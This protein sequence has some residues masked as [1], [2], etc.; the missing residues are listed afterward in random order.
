VTCGSWH[1]YK[2][3]D[4]GHFIP[5]YHKQAFFTRENVHV[6][7]TRCN[8][9]YN[10]MHVIYRQWMV[11]KYGEDFIKKLES[12]TLPW[13]YGK[14]E[15]KAISDENREIVKQLLSNSND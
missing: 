11:K 6:Q 13:D 12:M 9:F 1:P 2:E 8:C 5:A 15:L 4:A 10:G 7:C 14:M 3:V